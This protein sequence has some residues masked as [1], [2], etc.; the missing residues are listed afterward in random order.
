MHSKNKDGNAHTRIGTHEDIHIHINTHHTHIIHTDIHTHTTHR[1]M[2]LV[3][4]L[5]PIKPLESNHGAL[6]YPPHL[7]LIASQRLFYTA[8]LKCQ[9]ATPIV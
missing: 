9:P 5:L 7:T 6:L 2:C 4:F 8:F 1:H 3:S